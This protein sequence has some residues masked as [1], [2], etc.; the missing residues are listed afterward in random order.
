MSNGVHS[1]PKKC[2]I[3]NWY[4]QRQL[5]SSVSLNEHLNRKNCSFPEGINE[6]DHLV[7]AAT[8]PGGSFSAGTHYNRGYNTGLLK[9]IE[10]KPI[11]T[12]G[13]E[14]EKCFGEFHRLT[15]KKP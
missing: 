7:Y 14:D 12:P 4:C 9:L 6:R 8:K 1:C 2:P 10:A 5:I 11:D 15:D 3:T 13:L